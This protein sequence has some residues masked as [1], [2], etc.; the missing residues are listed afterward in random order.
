MV[1]D[2]WVLGSGWV[3][4]YTRNVRVCKGLVHGSA[5]PQGHRRRNSEG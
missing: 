1:S 4:S 3:A 5:G 2:F